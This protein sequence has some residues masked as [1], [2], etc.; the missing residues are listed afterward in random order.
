GENADCEA[1]EAKTEEEEE[2]NEFKAVLS[3]PGQLLSGI[4]KRADLRL[5]APGTL[6]VSAYAHFFPVCYKTREGKW[7]GV[8]VKIMEMF[9][10]FANLRLDLQERQSFDGIWLD[11]VQ[12]IADVCI[13]GI[14]KTPERDANAS[15]EWSIP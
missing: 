8:D 2:K 9:C 11:P 13:G 12:G 5:L 7:A 3:Q 1:K 10:E 4:A 15:L 6:R 14:G